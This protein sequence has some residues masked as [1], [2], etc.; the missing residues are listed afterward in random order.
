[1]GKTAARFLKWLY[2]TWEWIEITVM[3][4]VMPLRLEHTEHR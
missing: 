1:M 4:S 2:A 3:L